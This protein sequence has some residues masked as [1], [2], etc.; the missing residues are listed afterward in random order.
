MSLRP[1]LSSLC[2]LVVVLALTTVAA[3]RAE[4]RVLKPGRPEQVGLSAARLELVSQILTEETRSGRVTSASVLVARRGVI[5]LRGGWGTL[6][7]EAGSP[8]AGPETVY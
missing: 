1:S 2:L 3:G 4:D 5:V 8:K 6:A 7:P